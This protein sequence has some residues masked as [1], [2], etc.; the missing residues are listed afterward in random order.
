MMRHRSHPWNEKLSKSISLIPSSIITMNSKVVSSTC[1]ASIATNP[2]GD[3]S[4]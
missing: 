1:W 2:A 3:P 4:P